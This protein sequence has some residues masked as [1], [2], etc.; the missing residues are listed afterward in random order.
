MHIS[1]ERQSHGPNAALP[2]STVGYSQTNISTSSG[3][4]V[5]PTTQR[6]YKKPPDPYLYLTTPASGSVLSSL[7]PPS[8]DMHE[9][10]QR[11]L[12]QSLGPG[13]SA[14]S[15]ARRSQ[16]DSALLSG[17]PHPDL[18]DRDSPPSSFQPHGQDQY[19]QHYG[20]QQPLLRAFSQQHYPSFQQAGQQQRVLQ[21]HGQQQPGQHYHKYSQQSQHSMTTNAVMAT[22]RNQ[23]QIGISGGGYQHH[24]SSLGTNAGLP[25]QHA[26]LHT[27]RPGQPPSQT[28]NSGA[29]LSQPIPGSTNNYPTQE[30]RPPLQAQKALHP[31]EESQPHRKSQVK[32]HP[33]KDS[34]QGSGQIRLDKGIDNEIEET[35]E[36]LQEE[37]EPYSLNSDNVP[38]DQNLV[39]PMCGQRFRLGQI[40][41]FRKHVSSCV[42]KK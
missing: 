35:A 38:Y 30:T 10:D 33:S 24:P 25:T 1:S 40:Q 19:Q 2:Q 8:A 18:L 32:S 39:C 23:A 36:Y 13:F 26:Y 31:Q 9:S 27:A 11:I 37:G 29:N 22:P 16:D 14:R 34:R 42:S 6:G 12:S 7:P 21:Q 28:A 15:P 5:V 17:G 20:G 3:S 41:K 4:R